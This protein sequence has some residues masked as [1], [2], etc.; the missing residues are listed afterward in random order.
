LNGNSAVREAQK[1]V[2]QFNALAAAAGPQ[3]IDNT[4]DPAGRLR[5]LQEL[6]DAG[7]LTEQEYEAKRVE[8]L[9]ST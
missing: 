2:V 3:A 8:I 1:Q 4:G 9:K 7:L 5:K 6:R